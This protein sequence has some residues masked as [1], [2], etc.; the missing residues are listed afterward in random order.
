MCLIL[1][2]NEI[3]ERYKLVLAAN[4]D[5][6]YG[7][8]SLKVEY[9]PSNTNILAGRD[10]EAGGTW[11]GIT[12]QGRL[13]ALTNYRDPLR[14]V[15]SPLSRGKLVSDYLQGIE[16][17][18]QYLAKVKEERHCYKPFNLLTGN[19]DTLYYYSPL[20]NQVTAVESGVH[21][22]S[23]SFLDTPW[24]KV[25]KGKRLLTELLSKEVLSSQELLEML[26]DQEVFEDHRLPDT[27]VGIELERTLSAMFIKG[28]KY[29][30]RASSVLLIDRNN[31]VT[32]TERSLNENE[33]EFTEVHF[34]F[35]I[36]PTD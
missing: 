7:R 35:D 22:L 33:Q 36:Q 3:H 31:H 30:T 29:G 14:E 34:E 2:A 5:E 17:P 21:G 20:K 12:G 15:E 19:Q 24:P 25:S 23:N 11:L 9:W 32:F 1:F 10:L 18:E 13:A 28:P 26:M 27:G 16:L 6:F 4:R 8:P